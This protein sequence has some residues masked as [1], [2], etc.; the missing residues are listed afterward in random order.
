MQLKEN[1]VEAL[2]GAVVL[3]VA[4]VF[5][6]YAYTSTEGGLGADGYALNARFESASGLGIGTDVRI[7]GIKVGTVTGQTLDPE[8]FKALISFTVREDVKLPADSTAVV[9]SEGLLGGN[10]L[11]LKPGYED[12]VLQ[13]GATVLYTQG[14]LD[15]LG[16]VGRFIGNTD[17]PAEKGD[18]APAADAPTP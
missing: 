5:V 16:L 13:P 7:S 15:I 12:T 2:I 9:A 3:V 14:S 8:T 11:E 1:L 10:Y 17:K 4:G 18:A 6:S